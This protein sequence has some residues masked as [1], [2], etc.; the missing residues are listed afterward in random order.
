MCDTQ[1]RNRYRDLWRL[2]SPF[3]VSCGDILTAEWLEDLLSGEPRMP[4]IFRGLFR[5]ELA[6]IYG[7]TGRMHDCSIQLTAAETAFEVC[8]HLHGALEVRKHRIHYGFTSSPDIFGALVKIMEQYC[9]MD[10]PLGV[11]QSASFPL[12]HAFE[13]GDHRLYVK[14]QE[15]LNDVCTVGGI[16]H[17]RLLLHLQLL[18]SMNA[19]TGHY[20]QVM[21]LGSAL[22]REFCAR[23]WWTPAFHVTVLLSLAETAGENHQSAQCWAGKGHEICKRESLEAESQA[24]YHVAQIRGLEPIAPGPSKAARLQEIISVIGPL[25]EVDVNASNNQGACTKLCLMA[26][27]Q[28]QLARLK[29]A[30][31]D[32]ILAR[33]YGSLDRICALCE[34]LEA[35][36]RAVVTGECQELRIAQL[37]FEGKHEANND[38]EEQALHIAGNLIGLYR[39]AGLG[40]QEANKYRMRAMCNVQ[41]WQKLSN[42]DCLVAAERDL[43]TACT[44]FRAASNSQAWL[45]SQHELARIYVTAW[46][47]YGIPLDAVLEELQKL[48]SIADRLRRE[49][50]ALNG[51][52]A[53]LQKQRFASTTSVVDLYKWAS[54]VNLAAQRYAELWFWSQKRKARS[55]SD[56]LGLGVI[57]PSTV[58]QAMTADPKIE[59]EFQKLLAAQSRLAN[60]SENERGFVREEI[61]KLEGI[62]RPVPQFRDYLDLRD[63]VFKGF[64]ELDTLNDASGILNSCRDV[65]FVDW[66]LYGDKIIMLV[67]NSALRGEGVR[68]LHLTISVSDIKRWLGQ[69]FREDRDRRDCLR[70]DSIEDQCCPMRELDPLISSLQ[71][72]TKPADLLI[73]SPTSCLNSLP[74]HALKIRDERCDTDVPLIAR[75]P[76]VYATS[77]PV[78]QLCLARSR[79]RQSPESAVFIGVY[80]IPKEAG[81]I[82]SQMDCLA[83]SWNGRAACG[84]DVTKGSFSRLIDGVSLVH[85]HGHCVFSGD[86]IL[87]QSL[88][89][90]SGNNDGGTAMASCVSTSADERLPNRLHTSQNTLQRGDQQ[91][92]TAPGNL[93]NIDLRPIIDEVEQETILQLDSTAQTIRLTVEDIFALPL[94]S[95]PLVTLVACDSTTQTIATGDEPLGI[96]TGLL[97]AG[98]ASVVGASWPIPSRTG[99]MFSDVFYSE[100]DNQK[101]F[102]T[103]E[104]NDNRL[105]DIAVALQKA[106]LHIRNCKETSETYHWGAFS[107]WGSWLYKQ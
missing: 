30:T 1:R 82:Y 97:C 87:Q 35:R 12:A 66:I 69:N 52:P 20:A 3:S 50:S 81:A 42:P 51:L 78:L 44:K 14:L 60:V 67:V 17:E 77:I 8:G 36:E 73:F 26:S 24:E 102:A 48:E 84:V 2:F 22:Y 45:G 104:H 46:E 76:V 71:Q 37:L 98:A 27:L 28:F 21:E 75:N 57:M 15:V 41:M 64:K 63:G 83:T 85:Y 38:K 23:K 55:L 89:L 61:A 103:S 79:A 7:R 18:A 101:S 92:A 32:V 93:T 43:K 54:G 59:L 90:S 70:E 25:V 6:K 62:L 4:D 100:L 99:R 65:I 19:G 91:S 106:V 95:S 88:V 34:S 9:R 86:N 72:C 40:M 29:G 39:S 5:L 16:S 13:K 74:L 56:M 11:L 47:K 94:S 53:L 49:L 107:L 33:A 105:V 80:D 10:C 96:L 58:K 68:L 31:P